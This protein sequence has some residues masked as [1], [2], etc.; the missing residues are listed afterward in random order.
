MEF[1]TVPRGVTDALCGR[2]HT[3]RQ[4]CGGMAAPEPPVPLSAVGLRLTDEVGQAVLDWVAAGDVSA[5]ATLDQH[6]A[7]VRAALARCQPDDASAARLAG[8]TAGRAARSKAGPSAAARSARSDTSRSDATRSEA[9]RPH[10]AGRNGAGNQSDPAGPTDGPALVKPGCPD[11]PFVDSAWYT[12][13]VPPLRLLLH[14]ACGFVESAVRAD[15]WPGE[16]EPGA[17]D[18]EAVRLAAVCRLIR[19]AEAAATLPPEL[20]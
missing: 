4:Y 8:Q 9:A 3:Q 5:S 6:V 12:D 19:Q 18:F 14:Y 16:R 11:V 2:S 1:A 7:A 20:R 13:D 17:A 15:W 10:H